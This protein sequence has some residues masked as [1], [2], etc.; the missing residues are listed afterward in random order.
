MLEK[1][2]N[3]TYGTIEVSCLCGSAGGRV[4]AELDRYGLP[5]PSVLCRDCGVVRTSPRLTDNSLAAFYDDEY[6]P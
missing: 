4:V 5:S 3:G 6:R 1:Y 2:A